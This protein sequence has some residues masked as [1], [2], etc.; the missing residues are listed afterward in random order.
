MIFFIIK[1]L[2]YVS[3]SQF[4]DGFCFSNIQC[5]T[6][7][8]FIHPQMLT[9][10]VFQSPN[11]WRVFFSYYQIV[12]GFFFHQ[13]YPDGFFPQ[14][15]N[16]DGFFPLN[17]LWPPDKLQNQSGWKLR[18]VAVVVTGIGG[19]PS[20]FPT[21]PIDQSWFLMGI[22]KKNLD[23]PSA[24]SEICDGNPLE[25]VTI[26]TGWVMAKCDGFW[27]SLQTQNTCKKNDKNMDLTKLS[28]PP[29][30]PHLRPRIP[31]SNRVSKCWMLLTSIVLWILGRNQDQRQTMSISSWCSSRLSWCVFWQQ[32][33][34]KKQIKQL[35]AGNFIVIYYIF[36]WANSWQC[37]KM[38]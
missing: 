29:K 4:C 10:F 23:G 6:G 16:P 14:Y 21:Y 32:T 8:R 22:E 38:R 7:F 28:H 15:R 20:Q 2:F 35:T 36:H 27:W 37:G 18:K 5:V 25:P 9:G 19:N 13:Q 30:T 34:Q 11:V 26:S 33:G 3:P 17:F 31:L 1:R 12:T 24:Y